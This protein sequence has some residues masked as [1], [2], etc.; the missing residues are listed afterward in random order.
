[1]KVLSRCWVLALALA[2]C[3]RLGPAPE[4]ASVSPTEA[5]TD[6]D[7]PLR[8]EGRN[9]RRKVKADLDDPARSEVDVS[10]GLVLFRG[11]QRIAIEEVR[12]A[13]DDS[14]VYAL[15]RA[16]APEGLWSLEL[17]DPWGRKAL[18]EDALTLRASC[19]ADGDC[20]PA[21]C[22]SKKCVAGRC[23]PTP[24]ADGTSCDDGQACTAADWCL[25][26]ACGGSPTACDAG[27][28]AVSSC[29]G[30][31]GCS[32]EPLPGSPACDDGDPCTS[33]D[34][35]AAGACLG[36]P[37]SCAGLDAG[38]CAAYA[39]AGDGGCELVPLGGVPCDDGDSCSFGDACDAGACRGTPY[40]CVGLDAGTC[41]VY[42][43]CAGDGGCLGTPAN[44]GAQCDDGMVCTSSDTCRTGS[45][46]GVPVCNTA[47]AACF[48][49]EPTSGLVSTRFSFDAGCSYDIEDG[50][51]LEFRFDFEGS[52]AYTPLRP[53]PVGTYQ[54]PDAG[55]YEA[56]VEVRDDAGLG[57]FASRFVSVTSPSLE[58]LVTTPLDEDDPDA[59]PQDGGGT[60]LSLR[61]A[62][63][64][65]NAAGGGR[66]IRFDGGMQ[67]AAKV[68]PS[69]NG[70]GTVLVGHGTSIDF[71]PATGTTAACIQLDGWGAKLVG[72]EAF[73]CKGHVVQLKAGT[74]V[75]ECRFHPGGAG[76][77]GPKLGGTGAVFG[78]RNEVWGFAAEGVSVL[79]DDAVVTGNFLHD[80]GGPG[81]SVA[82]SIDRAV[83]QQN[84]ILR[85]GGPG[86]TLG[87]S[88]T[89]VR[90]NTIYANS[91]GGVAS[92]PST[93]G[94]EVRNNLFTSNG[95][96][97]VR[98][99]NAEL[100][101]DRSPNG[102]YGNPAFLP[103]TDGGT[104]Q[105]F[106]DPLYVN[107]SAGDFRL[108]P[109]SPAVNAGVD[110]GVD[111]NGPGSGRFDSSAPDL[112]AFESP[113]PDAG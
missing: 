70:P 25:G 47:P 31:G 69:L 104:G 77:V 49:V 35:C 14:A 62:I 54:Y 83:V 72:L 56:A 112:G 15:L 41:L 26:G 98:A 97:A 50:V 60:G 102:F 43:A 91:G 81:V 96:Y 63:K 30:D 53:S 59:S 39:C 33:Q 21:V 87:R 38:Q 108:T 22:Q 4:L 94:S 75:S 66:V 2:G 76:G 24:L 37:Y 111:V 23:V 46:N 5:L 82:N 19:L 109:V 80:N 68:L 36:S 34:V 18:L 61:E 9:L 57:A 48:T 90:F 65:A 88:G 1:M 67:I 10:Y 79:A 92:A 71:S 101:A 55:L 45:C 42:V 20:P 51:A 7:T 17:T 99:T 105:L 110:L 44:E 84:L 113:Y 6:R 13:D 64:L 73:G 86:L 100:S 12:L 74:Q 89:R 32:Y 78:P 107:P 28:C 93:A 58:L 29:L 27:P 52:G 11:E 103:G 106:A 40:T 95:D 8:V 85:N 3:S 16:G